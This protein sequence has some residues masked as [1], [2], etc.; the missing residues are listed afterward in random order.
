M[1]AVRGRLRVAAAIA[2][3]MVPAL[4]VHGRSLVTFFTSPDDLV[5]L[6]QASGMVPTPFKLFRQ[7]SEVL[8]FRAMVRIAGLD[9]LP[10]HAVTMALH[11]ADIGLVLLFARAQGV[12]GCIAGLAAT[13]FG[14]FPLFSTVLSSA[15]GINDELAL[16]LA[17]GALLALRMKGVAG[18]LVPVTLFALALLSKESV[19]FLPLLAF[20]PGGREPLRPHGARALAAVAIAALALLPFVRPIR[21][22]EAAIYSVHFGTNLFHNLMTYASWAVNVTNPLPDLVSSYD[23]HAWHT[24]IWIALAALVSLLALGRSEPAVRIGWAWFVLGLLPVLPLVHLTYRHYL[25]PAI[26]GLALA[27][28]GTAVRALEWLAGRIREG[29]GRAPSRIAAVAA[30][31]LAVAYAAAADGLVRQRFAAR[32]PGTDL[33]LDPVFRRQEVA[34]HALASLN[35][36]LTPD[37]SRI[38]I[39]LPEGTERVFGARSGRE[40]AR[41]PRGGQPYDLLE[42]CLDHGRAVRLYFPWVDSVAFIARWTG[43]YR[44]FDLFAPAAGGRL[45]AMGSGPAALNDVAKWM[46]ENGWYPQAREHLQG[47]LEAYPGDPGLRLGYGAA[48]F[49]TGDRAGAVAELEQLVREAPDDSAAIM[50]RAILAK[51]DS[52]ARR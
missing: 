50:A 38:G 34:A 49:R 45:S 33:A 24:G 8:Y 51:L 18:I 14:V 29:R 31:A 22:S 42:E 20:L 7:L 17:L 39:L 15:V 40:Y 47:A 6:E 26:P 21:T 5:Y 23:P 46:M 10:F 36:Q 48:L 13:L 3:C 30:V 4:W 16:A 32:V 2:L 37:H 28:A 12:S 43:A 19:V 25:Y 52:T 41:V 1:P 9:P 35:R 44:D 27:S 11:L